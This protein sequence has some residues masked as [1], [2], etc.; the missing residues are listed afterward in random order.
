[1]CRNGL[2]TERG[3]KQAHGFCSERF[4]VD[5]AFAVRLDPVLGACGVLLEPASVVAKAWEHVEHV[6]RR[7]RWEPRSVL[8]TG[9][10][11]I[12]LLAALLGSQRGLDVHVLDRTESGAKPRLTRE[13]GATYHTG[14]VSDL[15][16][17]P[18]VVIECTGAAQV[19][20]DVMSRNSPG[21]IVCLTGLSSGQHRIEVDANSLNR[22]LVLENDVVLG[23]VNA[24]RRHYEK[25][26]AALAKADRK[27][28]EGLITRRVPL[29]RW[30]EAYDRQPDQIKTVL[31]FTL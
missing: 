18:D 14:A 26:A 2:Y 7:A 29:G 4:R 1:M 6:G 27:W 30:R 20:M 25:A 23:S 22:R 12:G 28:L 16:F 13:L 10:G 19:V 8:V 21:G 31:D 3:I 5:P 17:A 11:P 9:A 24:N 15:G